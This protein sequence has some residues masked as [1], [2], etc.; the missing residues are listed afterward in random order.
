VIRIGAFTGTEQQYRIRAIPGTRPL[1]QNKTGSLANRN[2][3]PFGIERA[4]RIIRHNAERVVAQSVSQ[5][6]TMAASQIP[7]AIIRAAFANTLEV[8]AQAV[9]T[10]KAG[11]ARP[12]ALRT[13]RARE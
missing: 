7:A 8:A 3:A 2:A 13:N 11:P 10:T 9:E 12:R 1:K 4:A 5:P 6:P